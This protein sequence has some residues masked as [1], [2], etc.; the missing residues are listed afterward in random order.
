MIRAR[1]IRDPRVEALA[2][3]IWA[4]CR[5]REWRTTV[6]EIADAFGLNP[7]SVRGIAAHRGWTGRLGG[8][9]DVGIDPTRPVRSGL[10]LD[11]YV[12]GESVGE[13]IE[14]VSMRRAGAG[15]GD[16]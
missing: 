5:E 12:R 2:F 10:L 3:R 8:V 1:K 4:W 13:I 16:G 6:G 15:H 11:H 14:A 9:V 7:N